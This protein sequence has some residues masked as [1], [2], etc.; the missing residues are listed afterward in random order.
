MSVTLLICRGE[1]EAE[2][3]DISGC[4]RMIRLNKDAKFRDFYSVWTAKDDGKASNTRTPTV[5]GSFRILQEKGAQ[6]WGIHKTEGGKILLNSF[7]E[8]DYGI[9]AQIE[10]IYG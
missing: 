6:L 5:T 7:C 1:F 4:H 10:L 2:V 9:Y 3:T 8:S